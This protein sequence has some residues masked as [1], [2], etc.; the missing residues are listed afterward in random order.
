MQKPGIFR[1]L[2]H[3]ESFYNC[4][5]TSTQNFVTFAKTGKPYITLK[6]QNAG[7]L[8]VIEYLETW[9]IENPTHNQYSLKD[10]WFS[11][12]I[13][14]YNCFSKVPY[15]SSEYAHLSISAD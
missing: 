13:K 2:E 11:K 6:I 9:E 4:I 12:I 10:L 5:A 1:I 14:N 7:I 3:S 15:L 8:R